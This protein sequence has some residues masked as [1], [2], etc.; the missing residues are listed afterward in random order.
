M[1]LKRLFKALFIAKA[2]PYRYTSLKSNVNIEILNFWPDYIP[3]DFWLCIFI[4]IR[5]KS[6]I[7][8]KNKLLIASVF[9]SRQHII[10]SQSKT[11]VFFTCENADRFPDYK[12]H[13]LKNVD[14][15]LGFEYFTHE[16]YE[17]FPLWILYVISPFNNTQVDIRKTLSAITKETRN[18]YRANKKFCSL[19]CSHDGNGLRT[20]IINKLE[21]ID[22]VDCGGRFMQNTDALK[23]EFKDDKIAF[24]SNYKFNIC[25]ENSNKSGYVTEKLFEAFKAGSIPIYWGSDNNPE[26]EVLNKNAIIF[27]ENSDGGESLRKQVSEL[28]TNE[29]LYREFVMQE[30]FAPHAAE[31]IADRIACFDRKLH[32]LLKNGL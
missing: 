30:Q 14:L 15:S 19:V 8:A 6:L 32:E 28:C 1:D 2:P 17:R 27:Y 29:K 31:Y 20:A 13:L 24:L 22:R 23:T 10:K 7:S 21:T 18:N 3:E 25:P 12:D 4:Q 5:Y 9:G 11:K 16:R 26:P